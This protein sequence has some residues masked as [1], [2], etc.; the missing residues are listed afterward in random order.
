MF[1]NMFRGR[2][3][4]IYLAQNNNNKVTELIKDHE[5]PMYTYYV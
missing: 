1:Y 3:R 2:L 4:R 5:P